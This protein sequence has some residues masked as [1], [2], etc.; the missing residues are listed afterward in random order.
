MT[1]KSTI[2]ILVLTRLNNTHVYPHI[3]LFM[4]VLEDSMTALG[5]MHLHTAMAHHSLAVLYFS[6]EQERSGFEKILIHSEKALLIREH[7]LGPA[8]L[9]TTRAALNYCK[10]LEIAE[11]LRSNEQE[12]SIEKLIENS[13]EYVQRRKAICTRFIAALPSDHI[14][15]A[16]FTEFLDAIEARCDI[17]PKQVEGEKL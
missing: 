8:H 15:I 11:E 12:N 10:L 9:D 17:S 6:Q 4:K 2:I 1:T 13:T 7:G 16:Y 3:K 14:D 5:E